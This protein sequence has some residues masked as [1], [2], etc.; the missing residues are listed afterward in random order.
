MCVCVFVCVCVCVRARARAYVK[1]GGVLLSLILHL[2]PTDLIS[3]KASKTPKPRR[4]T[5]LDIHCMVVY[6][7]VTKFT[8]YCMICTYTH[9][10][11]HTQTHTHT[12][13]HTHT[14]RERERERERKLDWRW[15][16]GKRRK[17]EGPGEG[18]GANKQIGRWRGNCG[19]RQRSMGH[20]DRTRIKRQLHSQSDH[21]HGHWEDKKGPLYSQIITMATSGKLHRREKSAYGLC[22]ARR[23]YFVLNLIPVCWDILQANT[24]PSLFSFRALEGVL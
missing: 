13:T 17:E 24:L 19:E 6:D 3:L 22:Q 11:K 4:C 7:R 15:Q 14:Q 12:H 8:Y 18:R 23:W 1:A 9:T 20:T 10:H 21:D 5:S 2:T 16:L